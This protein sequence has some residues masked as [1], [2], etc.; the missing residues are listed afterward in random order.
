MKNLSPIYVEIGKSNVKSIFNQDFGHYFP[1]STSYEQRSMLSFTFLPLSFSTSVSTVRR[2]YFTS[3]FSRRFA[4]R[5]NLEQCFLTGGSR[6]TFGTWTVV[7]GQKNCCYG[8]C[9][10]VKYNMCRQIVF[11]PVLWV[12]RTKV[13]NH[14]FRRSIHC[15]KCQK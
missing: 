11:Y 4:R 3:F 2:T 5:S 13:E 9:I 1:F 14:W 12:A 8:I 10:V 7:L 6:P 15:A